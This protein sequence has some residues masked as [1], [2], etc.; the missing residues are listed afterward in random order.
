MPTPLVSVVIPTLNRAPYLGATIDSVLRQ[1][2]CIV[3]DG[4]STDGTASILAAYGSRI[5][6]YSEPDDGPYDA[7]NKGWRVARGDVLAWLNA[8]D[9]YESLA[10]SRAVACLESHAEADIV[11]GDCITD[12]EGGNPRY[13]KPALPWDLRRALRECDC[14]I[15]QPAAFLR[16]R[17][18]ER[19]G[20]LR[21]S[22]VHDFDLWLRASLAGAVF[23]PFPGLVARA[24]DHRARISAQPE[25]MVPAVVEAVRAALCDPALPP[26]LR[27]S[28]I[29]ALSNAYAHGL[30]FA[31]AGEWRWTWHCLWHALAMDPSNAPWV[32]A[33]FVEQ[34]GPR[35]ILAIVEAALGAVLLVR[36]LAAVRIPRV[37]LVVG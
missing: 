27:G 12:D 36:G 19:V 16:R 2:P 8:D 15:G 32:M 6:A 23:Q 22:A 35:R 24:M 34:A 17:I 26:E 29:R 18:V 20:G 25:V 13:L 37:R 7:I 5:R 21:P 14:L 10:V 1:A 4:G 3:V 31:A 30:Y 11:Y 9:V 33:R 28:R